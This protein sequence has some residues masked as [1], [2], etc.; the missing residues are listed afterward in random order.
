MPTVDVQSRTEEQR[1]TQRG[2]RSC[3][4]TKEHACLQ[5]KGVGGS[6]N[7]GRRSGEHTGR[8]QEFIN[9]KEHVLREQGLKGRRRPTKPRRD[10]ST[11]PVKPSPNA[12]LCGWMHWLVHFPLRSRPVPCLPR[13]LTTRIVSEPDDDAEN[14]QPDS[15]TLAEDVIE[16]LN[17]HAPDT[18]PVDPVSEEGNSFSLEKTRLTILDSSHVH[19]TGRSYRRTFS[20]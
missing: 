17:F 6:R 12:Q 3:T 1:N 14:E 10:E 16:S 13:L 7:S 20:S 11:P 18:P 9:A 8:R 15:S 4:K 2:D 19:T 5:G